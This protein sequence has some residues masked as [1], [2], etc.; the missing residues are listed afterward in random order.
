AYVVYVRG[1]RGAHARRR[2]VPGGPVAARFVAGELLGVGDEPAHRGPVAEDAV[3]AR[4]DEYVAQ[5]GALG[6][7]RHARQPAGVRR[8]LAQQGAPGAAADD[9]HDVDRAV[10]EAGGV[11]DGAAVGE[12]ERVEDAAGDLG[13]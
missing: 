3:G 9:V 5:R 11:L 6:G 12:G 4:L 8:E 2:R 1:S 7:P 10:G 13:A